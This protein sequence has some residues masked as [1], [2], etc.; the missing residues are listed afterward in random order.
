MSS[1]ILK[2]VNISKRFGA[3][4]ALDKVTFKFQ[5][6]E[7]VGLVSDNAAKNHFVED[8]CRLLQA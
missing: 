6:G 8:Y 2:C 7:V 5:R 3:I 1:T 4:Q